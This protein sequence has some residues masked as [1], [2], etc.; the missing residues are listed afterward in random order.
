ML[1][2]E[3]VS[4]RSTW[5]LGVITLVSFSGCAESVSPQPSSELSAT[6][7]TVPQSVA[8]PSDARPQ[9]TEEPTQDAR[10]DAAAKELAREL[11][12]RRQRNLR[13]K[14]LRLRGD[15]VDLTF[16]ELEFDIERDA[17]FE[18][19]MLEDS[20]RQLDGK[21]V[22]IRGYMLAESVFQQRGIKK[23]VL[24]RD[25]RECCFGPG[26]YIY[27]NLQVDMEGSETV[28]FDIKPIAL[29]GTLSIR[30]WFGPDGKC[31]SVFHLSCTSAG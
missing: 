17:D 4:S 12:E 15:V 9:D 7:L 2:K 18:E 13:T 29:T 8:A 11:E 6:S 5:L 26:A 20:I 31:Y 3:F 16:D 25:N 24:I 14:M 23:F 19:S 22:V 27:H 30:P 28:D 21:K 1:I 10:K